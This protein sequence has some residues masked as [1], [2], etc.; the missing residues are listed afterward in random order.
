MWKKKVKLENEAILSKIVF[1][2][3]YEKKIPKIS[4]NT[5]S[6]YSSLEFPTRMTSRSREQAIRKTRKTKKLQNLSKTKS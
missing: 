3:P 6:D 4:P 2:E 1:G 5:N